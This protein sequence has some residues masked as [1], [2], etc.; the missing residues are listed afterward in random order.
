MTSDKFYFPPSWRLCAGLGQT[1]KLRRGKRLG[2]AKPS[3]S[4]WLIL[5]A[6]NRR[7]RLVRRMVSSSAPD[8]RSWRHR[9]FARDVRVGSHCWVIPISLSL[10]GCRLR[11]HPPTSLGHPRGVSCLCGASP[12]PG[13]VLLDPTSPRPR[14]AGRATLGRPAMKVG[15][16]SRAGRAALTRRALRA[17]AVNE[18]PGA[19]ESLCR[20]ARVSSEGA[21]GASAAA[22][23]RGDASRKAKRQARA[24]EEDPL[25][26]QAQRRNWNLAALNLAAMSWAA[27]RADAGADDPRSDHRPYPC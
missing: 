13:R 2:Q 16:R 9:H 8:S 17:A 5:G 6:P 26:D 24:P 22:R 12:A 23:R 11:G 20:E 7:P 1:V 18:P 4:P 15:I 19:V 21:A 27:R 3:L 14:I 10:V 25:A